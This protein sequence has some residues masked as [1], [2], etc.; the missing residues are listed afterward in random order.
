MTNPRWV[1]EKCVHCG[2]DVSRE[3]A[4]LGYQTCDRCQKQFAEKY[5]REKWNEK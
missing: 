1:P 5:R 3:S 4:K 2:G